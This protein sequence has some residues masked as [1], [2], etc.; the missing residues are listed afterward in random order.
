MSGESAT[1]PEADVD[2]SE[3]LEV[4]GPGSRGRGN[5]TDGVIGIP[6]QRTTLPLVVPPSTRE[7]TSTLSV[8]PMATTTSNVTTSLTEPTSAPFASTVTTTLTEPTSAPIASPRPVTPVPTTSYFATEA[9]VPTI[10]AGT[11]FILFLFTVLVGWLG[12]RSAARAKRQ[13]LHNEMVRIIAAIANDQPENKTN[14]DDIGTSMEAQIS[15]QTRYLQTEGMSYILADS[16]ATIDESVEGLSEI[17]AVE[18]ETEGSGMGEWR[19]LRRSVR[20]NA[21]GSFR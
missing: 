11:I 21:S 20:F 4:A 16:H 18:E 14:S 3:E 10:L 5:E 2:L 6:E 7:S 1:F 19:A 13:D 9:L 17:L 15:D 12:R 8:T